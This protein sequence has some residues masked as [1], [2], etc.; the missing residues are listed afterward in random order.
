MILKEIFYAVKCDR[1]GQINEDGNDHSYFFDKSDALQNVSDND[2]AE[3]LGKHYCDSCHTINEETDEVIVKPLYP[4]HLVKLRKF[5]D[6]V[7][8]VRNRTTEYTN[9]YY[10]RINIY[11]S[12]TLIPVDKNYIQEILGENLISINKEEKKYSEIE[13]LI[14]IKK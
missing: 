6:K 13:Y 2:W 12:K 11:N 4:D 5:L 7:V 8:C 9:E 3:L 10:V 1:C 14:V